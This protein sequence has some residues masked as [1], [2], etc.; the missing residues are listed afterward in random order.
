MDLTD[1]NALFKITN[2]VKFHFSV[3]LLYND[4]VL[5]N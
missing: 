5:I 1:D 4:V 3:W 2:V